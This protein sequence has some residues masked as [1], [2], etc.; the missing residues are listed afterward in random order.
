MVI[1]TK[2]S[3][4]KIINYYLHDILT[5]INTYYVD[6]QKMR[7]LQGIFRSTTIQGAIY[8]KL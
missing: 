3:T 7:F 6:Y 4:Q 2:I 1:K 5:E 8:K